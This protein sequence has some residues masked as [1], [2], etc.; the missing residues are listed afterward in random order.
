[1][2]NAI[3][4]VTHTINVSEQDVAKIVRGREDR[5]EDIIAEWLLEDPD[6]ISER[7]GNDPEIEVTV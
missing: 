2:K 4:T 5:A 6:R 7:I 1:M 3:V